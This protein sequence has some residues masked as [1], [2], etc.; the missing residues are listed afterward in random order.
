MHRFT[1]PT[2]LARTPQI[3]LTERFNIAFRNTYVHTPEILTHIYF[4]LSSHLSLYIHIHIYV[5]LI[6]RHYTFSFNRVYDKGA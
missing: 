3:I 2:I 6:H 4:Y 1:Y 5:S